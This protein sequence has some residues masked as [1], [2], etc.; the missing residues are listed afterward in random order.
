MLRRSVRRQFFRAHEYM[1]EVACGPL[2]A[3][4]LFPLIMMPRTT[5]GR[6]AN[7]FF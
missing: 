7:A 2:G 5:C 1:R 6:E 3:V 4:S